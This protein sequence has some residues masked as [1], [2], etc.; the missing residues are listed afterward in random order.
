MTISYN[1]LSEYLPTKVEP[2]KLSKILTSIGL[3]VESLEKYESIKGGLNGLIT[4]EIIECEKHP[5]ADKLKVTKVNTGTE[6]LQV[7]CG[8]PN[9]AAG[10]KVILALPG[11][12]IYPLEGEPIT[13][14]K[15]KIRGVESNGMIC[16]EDEIGTGISHDGIMVLPEDT[17]VGQPASALFKVYE[18]V[19]F[20]I[21]LTPNRMDA[22]SHLGV[23]KDI[24]AWLSHHDKKGTTAVLPYKNGFKSNGQPAP[25]TVAVENTKDCPRYA[26]I[27]ISD[28]TV[29]ESPEWLK[30]RLQA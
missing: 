18:D 11:T 14:K 10:Q 6:I 7:V 26:G 8:A 1:W 19:V 13:L 17:V 12:T 15:A 16:A 20:E 28:I 25:V 5:D 24:C 22:M 9:A 23:A 21:G 30:R 29:G 2:E 3:E 27:S 4:A